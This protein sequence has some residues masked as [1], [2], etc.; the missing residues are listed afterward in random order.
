MLPMK[1]DAMTFQTLSK[2]INSLGFKAVIV[3]I[4][5]VVVT[6]IFPLEAP[7]ATQESAIYWLMNTEIGYIL[8]WINQIV[9]MVSLSV[10]IAI[11]A[12]QVVEDHPLR[13]IISWALNL[14]ATM[15]F[16]IVKFINVWSVPLM[17]KALASGSAE[18]VN[19]GTALNTLAPSVAF[20]FGPSLDYLG[21]ALYAAACLVVWRPLYRLSISTKVAAIGFL[22]FGVIYFLTLVAPYFDI[23]AQADIEG[24]VLASA[25][26]LVIACVAL[27]FRF[28]EQRNSAPD[29]GQE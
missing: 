28:K 29:A 9:S 15:A 14:M 10:V 18:S 23:L 5:T 25:L 11:A 21:F 6:F 20:G 7:E 2:Q 1:A 13:A 8:G 19:A 24:W 22:L 12:W 26:P 4:L 16:F 17:A 3:L 27:F